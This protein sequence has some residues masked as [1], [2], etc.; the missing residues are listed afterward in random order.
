MN[1][2]S[3]NVDIMGLLKRNSQSEEASSARPFESEKPQ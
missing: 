1:S 2:H 3:K